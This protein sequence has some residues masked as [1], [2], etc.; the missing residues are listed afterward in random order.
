MTAQNND[1]E[2]ARAIS[3]CATELGPTNPDLLADYLQL[4][5]GLRLPR[6]AVCPHHH[7]PLEYLA[8]AFFERPGDLVVWACRGGG[9][10]Q[11]AAA[12]TLLDLVFKPG[13]QIRILGGSFEQARTM[14]GYLCRLM[15]RPGFAELLATRPTCRRLSLK[16]GS[17]VEVLAQSQRSVRGQR[18]QKLRCDE[19]E[20]FDPEVWEAAQ[21][22]TRSRGE[23]SGRV[24]AISTFH[25][26]GGVM[27][28]L[29]GPA[30]LGG[31][32]PRVVGSGAD[33]LI[34]GRKVL[35]WCIWDV[36][37]QCPPERQCANCALAADCGGKARE[38]AGFIPVSDVLDMQARV[39]R[40]V[41][42]T[43]ML[44]LRPRTN[45]AVFPA[46]DPVEHVRV[47]PAENS[48]AEVTRWVAG[49]DFG[50]R[51]FVCLW[52]RVCGEKN[53]HFQV[54]RELVAHG[55]IL[56]QNVAEM[57][58]RGQEFIA[59]GVITP[60]R[61]KGLRPEAMIGGVEVV[62]CDSAG[63]QR[64]GQTGESDVGRLRDAGLIV[65]CRKQ[66][67]EEGI[68]QIERL[69]TPADHG[70]IRLTIH[71]TCTNLIA[72]L[73]RYRRD[74]RNGAPLKDGT[75]D[76]WIDALRYAICGVLGPVDTILQR[77]Y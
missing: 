49:V 42:Q 69:L 8:H 77:Y 57:C 5:C 21:L 25:K 73:E 23:A 76:H 13:T 34:A 15:S 52:I 30:G 68:G 59:T 40:R 4:Y 19:V 74:P 20:L 39:S 7:S 66:F 2:L 45:G 62:H 29:I 70:P 71:P 41:W 67:I 14:Y 58:K 72:A 38:A 27:E 18:I 12:A 37:A 75:Y 16:N 31:A 1:R 28:G 48:E 46:F 36:I 26:P 35:S 60:R 55:C 50:L 63:E 9:K 43:E 65:R 22:T 51:T 24:E 64:N 33:S 10:T 17:G 54:V 11:L 47:R 3:R 32:W 44:C 6:T 61:G 53:P 56:S